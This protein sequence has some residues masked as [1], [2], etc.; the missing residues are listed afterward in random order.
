MQAQISSSDDAAI[1]ALYAWLSAD[2]ELAGVV[3]PGPADPTELGGFDIDV[4]LTHIEA[5]ASLAMSVAAFLH[6]RPDP[7]RLIITRPDGAKLEIQGVTESTAAEIEEFLRPEE[8]PEE[9]I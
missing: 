1:D 9:H 5:I 3:S 2:R 7:E 6:N 8:G 4:V